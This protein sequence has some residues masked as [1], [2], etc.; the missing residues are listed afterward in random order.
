MPARTQYTIDPGQQG[1]VRVDLLLPDQ[2]PVTGDL[3]AISSVG[4]SVTFREAPAL[5]LN[6]EV[7]VRFS[8]ERLPEPVKATVHVQTRTEEPSGRQYGFWFAKRHE[9]ETRLLPRLE[10]L[11]NRRGADRVQ[12]DANMP[13][14]VTLESDP[15]G[16]RACGP[17][18]SIS[19]SGMAVRTSHED[20]RAFAGAIRA[21]ASFALPGQSIDCV[22]VSVAIKQRRLA[23][24]HVQLGLVFEGLDAPGAQRSRDAITAYVHARQ[25]DIL[26]RR[27]AG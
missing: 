4:A 23:G 3:L 17:L 25:E 11:F 5:A 1:L 24:R 18:L 20:E 13:V 27:R 8:G 14:L 21:R 7:Q 16:A 9:I 26:R 19:T 12:P 6:Q 15:P 2:P 10:G 22:K